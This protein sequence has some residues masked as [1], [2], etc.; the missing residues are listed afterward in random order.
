MPVNRDNRERGATAVIVAVVIAMLFG[1]GVLAVDVAHLYLSRNELQGAADAC[2]LRGAG[3]LYF[4]F[5]T[6]K[7]AAEP[8]TTA[9]REARDA[10]IANKAEKTAVEVNWTSGNT[11]DVQRGHW[12]FGRGTLPKGF[13]PSG[14]LAAFDLWNKTEPELDDAAGQD[15]S[16]PAFINAVRCETR[17]ESTPVTNFLA[18]ILGLFGGPGLVRSIV[19]AEAVAVVGFA[20]SL[21]PYGVDQPFGIC[22]HMIVDANGDYTCNLGRMLNNNTQTAMWTSFDQSTCSA[23]SNEV[24]TLVQLCASSGNSESLV[25]GQELGS[26]NGVDNSVLVAFQNCW[27]TGLHRDTNGDGVGDAIL[28]TDADGLPNLPWEIT[29]PVI[30]CLAGTCTPIVGAVTVKVLWMVDTA[31]L[32][33]GNMYDEAPTKMDGWTCSSLTTGGARPTPDCA[34]IASA[35]DKRQCCWNEFVAHFNLK[36]AA[37]NTTPAPYAQK[38]TYFVPDCT[39]HEPIGSTGGKNFGILAKYPVLVR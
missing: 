12:S 14:S 33:G 5:A 26:T 39:A 8:Q 25:L 3:M 36:G 24:R 23:S 27:K 21:E 4:D 35:G 1:I 38:T 17:R 37:N 31:H 22:A 32:S 19:R 34:T 13:S 7:Y 10:G 29:L 20:G 6:N 11:G 30:N 18:P 15:M 28:D 16:H 9:N 2:A